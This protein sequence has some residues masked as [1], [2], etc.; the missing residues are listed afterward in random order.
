MFIKIL[1][2]S[3]FYD[4]KALISKR[5]ECDVKCQG[6]KCKPSNFAWTAPAVPLPAFSMAQSFSVI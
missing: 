4:Q 2:M 5:E 6:N 3:Y 1:L